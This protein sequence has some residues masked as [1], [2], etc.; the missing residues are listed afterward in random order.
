MV[1]VSYKGNELAT[2][3]KLDLVVNDVVI[4]ELKAVEVVLPVHKAQLLSYMKLTGMR[5]GVLI[6]FHTDN[7]V[8]SAT[9]LVNEHFAQLPKQ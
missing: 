2:P 3:V 5:K 4:I 8:R 7:I 9:H 1:P 6:N